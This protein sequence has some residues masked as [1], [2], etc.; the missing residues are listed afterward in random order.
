M[1]T[2]CCV[3]GVGCLAAGCGTTKTVNSTVP[4]QSPPSARTTSAAAPSGTATSAA[5]PKAT[6]GATPGESGGTPGPG[7]A[8]S[9]PAPAFVHEQSPTG[10]LGSAVAAVHAAGYT[11]LND[12]EYHQ[13]QTL[14][15]L[16]GSRQGAGGTAEHAFF[17][18]GSRY[19]G[20]DTSEPSAQV[21][22]VSQGDTEV[23]LA[24]SLYRSGAAAGEADV[25][26]QLNNG[27]LIA[28][29]PIPAVSAR[30]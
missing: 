13:S 9:A 29:T 10:E 16:L 17:F 30:R 28:A 19:I 22:V 6:T 27:F 25:K 20:T 1:S 2:I 23:T 8:R 7:G 3:A 21:R 5:T 15:V 14:R 4:L 26:F 12:S 18:I 11:P 24:Y